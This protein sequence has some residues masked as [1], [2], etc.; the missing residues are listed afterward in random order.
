M[1]LTDVGAIIIERALEGRVNDRPC[2]VIVKI[3]KPFPDETGGGSWCCPYS[4]SVGADERIFYGAGV[5]SLQALRIAIKNI[6]AELSTIY[7]D[8]KLTWMGDTDLGFSSQL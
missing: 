1:K 4:I 2:A 8:L 6:D 3:G 7:R 5:D